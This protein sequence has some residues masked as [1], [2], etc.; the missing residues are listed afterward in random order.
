MIMMI[1]IIDI[2]APISFD[3]AFISDVINA[4]YILHV[5][6]LPTDIMV[7]RKSTFESKFVNCNSLTII[8]VYG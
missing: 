7:N 4:D 3:S 5:I 2:S 8:L 1:I 6:F